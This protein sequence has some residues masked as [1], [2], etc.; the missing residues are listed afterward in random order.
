MDADRLM[1]A[2][3]PVPSQA[4]TWRLPSGRRSPMD[5]RAAP[6]TMLFAGLVVVAIVEAKRK[7]KDV[8]G[9]IPQAKRYSVGYIIHGSE[10]LAEQ[11]PWGSNTGAVSVCDER[12]PFCASHKTKSGILVSRRAAIGESSGAARRLLHAGRTARFG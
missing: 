12:S 4:K 7:H 9:V 3:G 1:F 8:S 10:R 5:K 6:T 11:S 2:K